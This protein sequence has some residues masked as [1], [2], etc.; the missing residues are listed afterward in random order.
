MSGD[1]RRPIVLV[2]LDGLGD[3]A[4]D[5]LNGLTPC[6]AA[7]TP[8]LDQLCAQGQSGVLLPFGPGRATSSERSHWSLFGFGSVR[9]PGRAALEALGVGLQPPLQTPLFQIALR[10][11]AVRN[12][13]LYLGARAQRGRDDDDAA[14]LFEA[15]EG[16][17]RAG[18]RFEQ[19]PLRC[20]EQVLAVHG[21]PTS[22][23]SDS[24]SLFDHLHP[25]MRPRALQD[26]DDPEAA[27]QL[28]SALQGWLIEG[29]KIL[30]LHPVN[31]SR[32]RLGLKPL[33]TPVSKWA[34]WIDPAMPGFEEQVGMAG[35]AV[36]DTA[37]YRGLASICKMS[38]IDI[39]Y[40]ADEP[41]NDMSRRLAAAAGLLDSASF[42]HVHVK[43]TDE[44]GHSKR[45]AFKRDVIETT[46][47]GLE[48]LLELSERAV[49]AVT[50][51]HAT[52]SVGHLMHSGD[53]TPLVVAGP[54]VRADRTE[55]FG[56]WSSRNGELG[57]L[58]S[59]DV[60]PLMIGFANRPFFF[61]HRPGP[62]ASLA[63]PDAPEPMPI[64]SVR[65][66]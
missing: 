45:P 62:W 43:A 14:Q 5:E 23:V 27:G 9:F 35:A 47:A 56:E 1:D 34:S 22:H 41:T 51:D 64:D 52:P 38:S 29:R 46:D 49:V 36:T 11:G 10:H 63:L 12:G 32:Q 42:V 60:L 57:R 31:T 48:P 4:S 30:R 33:D 61:G 40:D 24:D 20:G 44:A 39:A 6:E 25:W 54:D 8:V 65:E 21:A 13:A 55:T 28:A 15:L 16:R 37:L 26:A 3:R 19:L 66:T 2:I 7:S 59:D 58:S 17:D 50:G 18:Y 53:P